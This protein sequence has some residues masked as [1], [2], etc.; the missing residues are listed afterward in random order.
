MTNNIK[1]NCH[2]V[3]S[4]SLSR[5]FTKKVKV[6]VT[7]SCLTLC[8][9]WTVS[10]VQLLS[11]VRL[12]ATHGL[13]HTRPPCPSPT[14]GVYSNSC[15]LSRWCPSTISS[16]DVPFSH[17]QSF[18]VSGSFLV[19]QFFAS[20]GQNIGVSASTS[21]LPMNIQDW[22]PLGWTGWISLQRSMEFCSPWNFPDQNIG[23]SSL[24]L[25]QG[26]FPTTG[27]SPGLPHCRRITSWAAFIKEWHN[28]FKVMK[29][30]VQFSRSVIRTY[31]Q[32]YSTQQG[33]HSD[34]TEKTL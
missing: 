31:N 23:V 14:P 6:K 13:Q 19:S 29:D 25:L 7:Q 3:M 34:L 12:F 11:H 4:K 28:I 33:S 8:H 21:V 26:I 30:S 22:F 10:S 24:C 17:L 2:K 20:D 5:K 9:P 32:K 15:P 18:P 16:S 1:G 27:S